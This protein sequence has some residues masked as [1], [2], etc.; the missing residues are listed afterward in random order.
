MSHFG[1]LDTT[2]IQRTGAR[3]EHVRSADM[4]R[5]LLVD[6]A[7]VMENVIQTI[8]QMAVFITPFGL[9]STAVDMGHSNRRHL[10]C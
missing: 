7:L 10:W 1:C 5:G 8:F 6:E 9:W 3:V 4:A 2:C